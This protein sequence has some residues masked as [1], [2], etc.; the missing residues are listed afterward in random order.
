MSWTLWLACL[1]IAVLTTAPRIYVVALFVVG[2]VPYLVS[3]NI[4]EPRLA[5]TAEQD[6][7]ARSNQTN[8]PG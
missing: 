1:G 6:S 5:H 7:N 2:F 4:I 3:I 8:G